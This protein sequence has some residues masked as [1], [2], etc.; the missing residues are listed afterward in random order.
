MNYLF[1][2]SECWRS[3]NV[4]SLWHPRG[5]KISIFSSHRCTCAS[6]QAASRVQANVTRPQT[7]IRDA[8]YSFT[9][10]V[11]KLRELSLLTDLPFLVILGLPS[12]VKKVDPNIRWK[13][14]ERDRDV[15]TM[16][17]QLA[18]FWRKPRSVLYWITI[19]SRTYWQ[20]IR[21]TAGLK[22]VP[23]AA[24]ELLQSV[25]NV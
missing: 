23:Q 18:C 21:N 16:H 20:N 17:F 9:H 25:T 24:I 8:M 6:L 13:Q 15:L 3:I 11:T 4:F 14:R 22:V 5:F 19:S 10:K 1:T 7:A 12:C 2:P